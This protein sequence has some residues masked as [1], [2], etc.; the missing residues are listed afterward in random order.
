MLDQ[1]L[2]RIGDA[3]ERAGVKTAFGEPYQVNGRTIIPVARV[4]Y[5]VGFGAGRRN[6]A[7]KAQGEPGEGGGGGARVSVRPVA[8]LEIGATETK[9]TPIVDVTRLVLAGMVLAAW[10]VFWISL[11][12]RRLDAR[13]SAAD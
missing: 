8:V 3:Q 12:V 6:G 2:T 9:V 11:T 5:G 4:G 13:R 7:E 10:N 1:M